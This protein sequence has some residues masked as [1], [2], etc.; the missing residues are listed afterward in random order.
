MSARVSF[1]GLSGPVENNGDGRGIAFGRRVHQDTLPI[2]RHII[3]NLPRGW[4][5]VVMRRPRRQSQMEQSVHRG[6]VERG[7]IAVYLGRYQLAVGNQVKEFL[8]SRRERG[9]EPPDWETCYLPRCSQEDV[10]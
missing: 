3:S 4:T 5:K 6:N 7:S 1:V 2:R 10:I 8:A 9:M